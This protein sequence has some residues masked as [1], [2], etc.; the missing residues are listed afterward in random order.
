[1]Q[2]LRR[3]IVHAA[4]YEAIAI[5]V[6]TAGVKLLGR[7]DTD[8]ALGLAI[9]TSVLAVLW[10]MAFNALFEAWERRQASRARTVRRR[11]LHAVGFEVGLVLLTVPAIMW[12][13]DIGWWAAL[14]TDL[15]L[16]VFFLG[17][18]FVFNWVFDQVFGLPDSAAQSSP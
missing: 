3:R 11:A 17:Y 8:D 15:T 7:S 2:G 10:N 16:V 6:V 13:L 14:L 18:T 12:W 5:V 1:M 9:T 4:L